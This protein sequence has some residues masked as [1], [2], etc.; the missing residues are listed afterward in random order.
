[1]KMSDEDYRLLKQL[2]DAVNT[3]LGTNVAVHK[4]EP[5][6]GKFA[7]FIRDRDDLNVHNTQPR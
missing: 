6:Q 3:E 2:V 5:L 1:M 4:V 7:L